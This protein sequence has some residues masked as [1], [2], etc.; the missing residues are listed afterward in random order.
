MTQ[1]ITSLER[2][3]ERAIILLAGADLGAP[4]ATDVPRMALESFS[5]EPWAS[6]TLEG[7]RHS[8]TVAIIGEED[9]ADRFARQ[10]ER[11][12]GADEF[13]LT[14]GA[15]VDLERTGTEKIVNGEGRAALHLHFEALTLSD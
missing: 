15:L 12:F 5:S 11:D 10:V 3:L 7:Y 9:A 6:A 14:G 13:R 4:L 1:A 8:F 2:L